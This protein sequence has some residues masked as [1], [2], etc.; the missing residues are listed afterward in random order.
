MTKGPGV[1]RL[2]TAQRCSLKVL[3]VSEEITAT[4]PAR[5]KIMP[6][7]TYAVNVKI[8]ESYLAPQPRPSSSSLTVTFFLLSLEYAQLLPVGESPDHTTNTDNSN[9][10][11]V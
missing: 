1:T 10:L 4:F 5:Q 2:F 3:H 7:L 9:L 11:Y 6:H 8:S